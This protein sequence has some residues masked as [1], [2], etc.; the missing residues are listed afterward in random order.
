MAETQQIIAEIMADTDRV[1]KQIG[2]VKKEV[3]KLHCRMLSLP[4]EEKITPAQAKAIDDAMEGLKNW[5][6]KHLEELKKSFERE[7]DV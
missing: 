1:V 3:M 6:H 5:R 4:G 7:I 2:E